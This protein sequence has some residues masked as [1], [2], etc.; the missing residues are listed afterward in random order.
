[1]DLV[2]NEYEIVEIQPQIRVCL[3]DFRVEER[4]ILKW[5][6]ISI[7][8]LVRYGFKWLNTDS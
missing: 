5:V 6:I 8:C 1:M 2:N 3:E 4:I 7:M